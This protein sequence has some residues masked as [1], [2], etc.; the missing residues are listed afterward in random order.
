MASPQLPW[1]NE[2]F[3]RLKGKGLNGIQ[4][5]QVKQF[6]LAPDLPDY[7]NYGAPADDLEIADFERYALVFDH[8]PAMVFVAAARARNHELY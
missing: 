6:T 8:Q 5:H 1:E 3:N 7:V 4:F 2:G